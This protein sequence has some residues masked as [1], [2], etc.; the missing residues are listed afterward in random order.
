M[1][2]AAKAGL[3]VV[4]IDTSITDV[5]DIRRALTLANAKAIYFKPEHG[6]HNYLKLLRKS[7]PEFFHCELVWSMDQQN[8]QVDF[9]FMQMMTLEGNFSTQSISLL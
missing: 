1:V 3:K 7:I 6:E 8:Y 4:D 9:I 2:A 5:N